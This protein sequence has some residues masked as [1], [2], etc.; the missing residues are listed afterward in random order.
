MCKLNYRL[1]IGER[2]FRGFPVPLLPSTIQH[3]GDYYMEASFI[4]AVVLIWLHKLP[5]I[6]LTLS[7][8]V[9]T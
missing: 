8:F 1:M 3:Q 9:W 2:E 6:S 5:Q 4:V 7:G